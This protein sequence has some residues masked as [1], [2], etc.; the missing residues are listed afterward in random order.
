LLDTDGD[1][2]PDSKDQC[3]TVAAGPHPDHNRAGCPDTDRD[4]D[5]I[6][7]S[8]DLCPDVATGRFPDSARLGCPLPDRDHDQVPDP[9]DACPDEPGAP[10]SDP[11]KNGCP[12]KV[13]LENHQ[14]VILSP[15]LFATGKAD[16]LAAS[17]IVLVGVAEALRASPD[18]K[19]ISIEGH[20]DSQGNEAYNMKLSERR[21]NTVRDWLIAH[22]IEGSRLEAHGYGQTRPLMLNS[23]AKGRSANRRVEFHLLDLPATPEAKP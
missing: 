12:G 2:I 19:H 18:L 23:T 14:I 16:L 1:G 9:V 22:G 8:M 10:H 4:G 13:K 3:P 17:D 11:K 6:F 5:Q 21:A 15:V 20:T 7:D